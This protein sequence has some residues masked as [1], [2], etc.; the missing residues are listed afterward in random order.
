MSHSTAPDLR[1]ERLPREAYAQNF[2]DAAPR[3]TRTQALV[4]AERCLYCHD[5]PCA[6][7]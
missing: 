5:A 2:A 7:A 1:A 3:L 6:T 4:E